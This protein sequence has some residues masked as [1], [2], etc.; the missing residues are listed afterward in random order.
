MLNFINIKSELESMLLDAGSAAAAPD[1]ATSVVA[2][3]WDALSIAF[4]AQ[5][6]APLRLRSTSRDGLLG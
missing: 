2:R 5:I 1:R 3:D 4:M 6:T